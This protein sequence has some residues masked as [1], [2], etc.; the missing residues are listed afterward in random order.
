MP[1]GISKEELQEVLTKTLQ[2][3]SWMDPESHRIQHEFVEQQ[4]KD[5]ARAKVRMENVKGHVY[6]W[7]AITAITGIGLALWTYF[8]HLL[9]GSH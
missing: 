3:K 7:A 9:N 6:G 8:K 4:M 1:E 5:K 2:E